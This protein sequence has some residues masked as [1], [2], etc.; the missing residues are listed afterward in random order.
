M[1]VEASE[2]FTE[3]FFV[4]FTYSDADLD[5]HLIK[6][7][8]RQNSN[9][10][11]NLV[12]DT[13]PTSHICLQLQQNYIILLERCNSPTPDKADLDTLVKLIS[14]LERKKGILADLDRQISTA[15]DEEEVETEVLEA[16]EL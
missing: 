8:Q 9:T 3:P 14:Q 5:C 6:P 15:I 7:W 4:V 1:T 16:E 13:E 11:Y 10:F 12:E 2:L